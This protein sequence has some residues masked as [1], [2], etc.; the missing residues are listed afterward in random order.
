MHDRCIFI[1]PPPSAASSDC[2]PVREIPAEISSARTSVLINSYRFFIWLFA[3]RS[4]F[5]G[6]FPLSPVRFVRANP[7]IAAVVPA[8]KWQEH[9]PGLKG[10][11]SFFLDYTRLLPYTL[12]RKYIICICF[13]GMGQGKISMRW[14]KERQAIGRYAGRH[15]GQ[16]PVYSGK[17]F[18]NGSRRG[19]S[20]GFSLCSGNQTP[21]D[22]CFCRF[23][24]IRS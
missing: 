24:P 12:P 23:F 20:I 7:A 16:D 10:E 3:P 4:A 1:Q 5:L 15:S 11:D 18:Q 14:H 21:R 8:G 9:L 2:S 22:N 13:H 17:C 19:L 6:L